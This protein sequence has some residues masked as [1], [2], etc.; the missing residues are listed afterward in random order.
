[1]ST[2]P[3][4]F[5]ANCKDEDAVQEVLNRLPAR[6]QFSHWKRVDEDGKKKMKIL[7]VDMEKEKFGE[8]FRKEVEI[9]RGHARRV[10]IQYEQLKLLKENLT[11][12]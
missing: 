5:I 9:F 12:R 7:T 4:V 2:S 1:M 8:L 3:D 11:G 10:Q 6:V